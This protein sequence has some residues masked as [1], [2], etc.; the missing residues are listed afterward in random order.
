MAA[1]IPSLPISSAILKFPYFHL[2]VNKFVS[3]MGPAS[4]RLAMLPKSH[5]HPTSNAVHSIADAVLFVR[6]IEV[7]K[8]E[9]KRRSM[10]GWWKSGEV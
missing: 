5:A 8:A 4:F 2:N 10:G 6:K 3:L 9:K 1:K 7:G